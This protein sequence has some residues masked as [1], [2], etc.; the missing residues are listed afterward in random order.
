[1]I[2]ASS[3]TLLSKIKICA[4]H[5]IKTIN[6]A[7]KK[8]VIKEKTMMINRSSSEK[9]IYQPFLSCESADCHMTRKRTKK[10]RL[11]KIEKEP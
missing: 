5:E 2:N 8:N 9:L 11:M 3:Q 7:I 1:M 6:S 10:K 4:L